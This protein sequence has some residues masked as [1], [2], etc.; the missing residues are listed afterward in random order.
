VA[1]LF[2]T[3]GDTYYGRR[4][5]PNNAK[6]RDRLYEVADELGVAIWDFYQVMGGA[7]SVDAWV[8][9]GLAAGDRVHLT[10]KG[11][12][13]QGDLLF[14]ALMAEYRRYPAGKR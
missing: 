12:R 8:R 3:P 9:N 4:S 5:N 6:A 1:I 14:D 10:I 13:F 2:T 11:Y 7:K